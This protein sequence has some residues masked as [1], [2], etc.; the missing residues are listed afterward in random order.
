MRHGRS[1]DS[2]LC[3]PEVSPRSTKEDKGDLYPVLIHRPQELQD[4]KD[5]K[6]AP[7]QP[8]SRAVKLQ[9][10]TP[11]LPTSPPAS[12]PPRRPSRASVT[13]VEAVSMALAKHV[14][15][16]E[17]QEKQREKNEKEKV[18]DVKDVKAKENEVNEMNE[19]EKV[20]ENGNEKE[21]N[22]ENRKKKDA[23]EVKELHAPKEGA[24]QACRKDVDIRSVYDWQN[25]KTLGSGSFG[26][27]FAVK[28]RFH[29]KKL[30]AIKQVSKDDCEH[31]DQ[32][33]MEITVLSTLDHPRVLHFFEAY[34]DFKDIYI[35]TELCTGGDLQQCMAKMQGNVIFARHTAEQIL[36]AL[37]YC[38][39]RGV[40]HRDLK[41]EN[42]LLVRKL[43]TANDTP[44]RLADFGLS[45]KTKASQ[46]NICSQISHIKSRFSDSSMN[47]IP[48]MDSFVG[49]AEFM[50]PEVM[51]VLNAE[52]MHGRRKFYDFRCDIWSLGVIV[53]CLL[54]GDHPYSLEELVAYVEDHTDLPAWTGDRV[55]GV[56][57]PA[58]EFVQ[59]CLLV[60]YT[61]RPSAR[62]LAAES[63]LK[64]EEPRSAF[65]HIDTDG[66]GTVDVQELRDYLLSHGQTNA[67]KGEQVEELFGRLDLN[68]DG[69]ITKSEFQE[70]F[71]AFIDTKSS[72]SISGEVVSD[73]IRNVEKF[74]Q[75]SQLKKAV[76][77]SA[78][79][80]LGG[81]EVQKLREIFES[82]DTNGD[83][84]IS[85]KEFKL[86]F[87]LM[88]ERSEEWLEEA[89][90]ALD[91]DGS[92]EIDY[93]EFLAGIMDSQLMERRDILWAAFQ[94]TTAL[95][96]VV[97]W[98]SGA[99]QE[100]LD[101]LDQDKAS[102]VD[103]ILSKVEGD[104]ELSFDAF[105]ELLQVS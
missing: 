65:S 41:P 3:L 38:H 31:L 4:A 71:D 45:H 57:G 16:V 13:D 86:S 10:L 70:G 1:S 90:V 67:Q 30:V 91:T 11:A 77:T 105:I 48:P 85:K 19:K 21:K 14:E 93:S 8:R 100:V 89:F 102:L 75:S 42:V 69:I 23:F 39:S 87:S 35:V 17:K 27:V 59:Q 47:D 97:L 64:T 79:R 88:G 28:H 33:R 18:K 63:F 99:V 74:T 52:I 44:M 26:E 40:C 6:D 73:I 60:P 94:E 12:P 101:S 22:K 61:T 66:S 25:R 54:R 9:P 84:A 32:L 76:L 7:T 58:L 78:A 82:V 2:E 68:E 46:S 80:H 104:G 72:Q 50:A 103:E 49:T 20:K 95:Q 24:F 92:G 55:K 43:H 98:T 37:I 36:R 81:Y 96:Y 83:G 15:L 5:S 53:Y 56:N 34:E 29:S 62:Q 51:A